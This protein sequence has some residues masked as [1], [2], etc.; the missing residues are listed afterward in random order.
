MSYNVTFLK[1]F[2]LHKNYNYLESFFYVFAHNELRNMYISKKLMKICLFVRN[3]IRIST[4]FFM[5]N[6]YEVLDNHYT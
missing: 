1:C 5:K 3:S 2:D 6:D 4:S